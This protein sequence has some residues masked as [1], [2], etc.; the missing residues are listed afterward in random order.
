MSLELDK[1]TINADI[2]A[3]LSPPI[4]CEI[5]SRLTPIRAS[6]NSQFGARVPYYVDEHIANRMNPHEVTWQQTGAAPFRVQ[7]LGDLPQVRGF[8]DNS[9]VFVNK[10]DDG[11]RMSLQEIK[12]MNTKIVDCNSLDEVDFD[13]LSVGDYIYVKK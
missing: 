6:I 8:R 9:F 4:N 11:F 5:N 10:G 3:R 7:A 12:D 2:H 1:N 13:K